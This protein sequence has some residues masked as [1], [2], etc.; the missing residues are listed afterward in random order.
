MEGG[1]P[2][3][4]VIIKELIQFLPRRERTCCGPSALPGL[5]HS[6]GSAHIPQYLWSA[7]LTEPISLII[8]EHKANIRL[9]I[10]SE[11]FVPFRAHTVVLAANFLPGMGLHCDGKTGL[12]FI[13][14]SVGRTAA[15]SWDHVSHKE[16]GCQKC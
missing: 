13:A 16:Q 11:N 9:T 10:A 1:G 12:E 7:F 5:C 3:C 6:H 14:Q 15:G 4:C 8:L 2:L